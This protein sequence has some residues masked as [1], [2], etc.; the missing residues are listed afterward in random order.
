[1]ILTDGNLV[2]W[3]AA[4]GKELWRFQTGVSGSSGVIS[5]MAGGEQYI[6][7]LAAGTSIPYNPP[8]GDTLWAFK[9]GG[10]ALYKDAAGN[11]VSGSS[12]APTPA[13]LVLRRPVGG[14][15]VEGSTV[16][17]TV[18]LGRNAR[19]DVPG[20]RDSVSTNGMNPTLMRV[21]VGTTVTFLNPGAATFPLN[22]NLKPHCATQFF[23]GLFNF[24]LNPGESAQYKFDRAGE[25]FFNDCTDPRPTGKVVVYHVPIDVPGA[26]SFTPKTLDLG[27]AKGVFTGV[28]GVVTAHFE[29]PDGYTTTG[30]VTL[31]TPLSL[32]LFSPVSTNATGGGKHLVAQFNKADIDNNTPEGDS[33]PLVLNV[34]VLQNGA[35]K[36]LTST[37]NVKVTK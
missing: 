25:Y 28:N 6:A 27:A 7:V 24:K 4:T 19:T 29:I 34:T 23:E 31:K 11:V 26:L 3:D 21:P 15:A 33:V 8:T 12:E 17:N 18:Y 32:T 37:V 35:Q 9:L 1:M 5:Y 13:P 30:E 10:N 22:P 14:S 2:A 36:Q 16:N 20:A